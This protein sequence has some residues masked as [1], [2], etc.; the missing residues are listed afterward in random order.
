[1]SERSRRLLALAVFTGSA[2]LSAAARADDV[3]PVHQGRI[4]RIAAGLAY[5]HER[6]HPSGGTG[7]AVH[8]GWGPALDVTAGKF[9]RPR[10]LVAGHLEAAAIIN[11]DETTL[12][13]TYKLDDTL[14]LI[15]AAGALVDFYPDPSRGLHA[16]G[17]LGIAAITDVDT[18]MGGAQTSWGPLVALHVGWERFVSRRWTAGAILR[19]SLYHYGTHT[20]PPDASA[21]GL[22]SSLLLTIA[23]D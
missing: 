6:W 13:M 15:D 9:V 23:H 18:H 10:L 20:P 16:G 1:M 2:V 14:R 22:L 7:D 8:A 19:L 17:A 4:V 5:L 11:R 21:N 12:G 3:G